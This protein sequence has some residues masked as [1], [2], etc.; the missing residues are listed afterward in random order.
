MDKTIKAHLILK[1]ECVDP[2]AIGLHLTKRPKHLSMGI[3]PVQPPFLVLFVDAFVYEFS[4][5]CSLWF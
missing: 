4:Q 2:F 1:F 5:V 3:S